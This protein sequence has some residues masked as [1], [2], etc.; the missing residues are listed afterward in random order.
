MSRAAKVVAAV[1]VDELTERQARAE[2]KR[3]A[4][5]IAHHDKLYHQ[6]DS[7]GDL[8]RRLRRAA[9]AQLKA[10]EARFPR[11]RRHDSPTQRVGADADRRPSPRSRHRVPMLSLDNAFAERGSPGLLRPPAPRAGARDRPQAGRRDRAGLRAQ[12][13]RALDQPAL[14][15]RRLRRR[16][17]ARRRHDRRGRHRQSAHGEGHPAQAEGQVPQGDRRARRGLHGAQGDFRGDERA[18]RK[19]LAR[20]SSPIR[21]TPPRARCA[22]SMPASPRAGRCASSPMPGA[23]PSRAHGRPTAN[24]SSSLKDWGF[25]VNPL[26]KLCRTPEQVR[27][28]YR[29]IERGAAVARP[30]T[31][32]ASSTRSTDSTGRSAWA[33]SSRAPRWAIAHK[34]PAEQARRG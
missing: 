20:R 18:R 12:D 29:K 6:Q 15:G 31:S 5:E 34:F 1:A 8:R 14:R 9:P 19:Q 24:S 27:E 21:A 32:T 10:I 26:S 4:E 3:L 2:L 25:R 7:P 28:F 23:R 11:A 13:R 33:S 17:H 30:T 16:R 22:S